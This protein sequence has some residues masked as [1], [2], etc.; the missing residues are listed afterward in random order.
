MGKVLGA[1]A[2][3]AHNFLLWT[4]WRCASMIGH[5]STTEVNGPRVKRS[6]TTEVRYFL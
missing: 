6:N 1:V 5:L 3:A 4:L 2:M